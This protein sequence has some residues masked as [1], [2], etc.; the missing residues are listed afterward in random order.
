MW[1]RP[2]RYAGLGAALVLGAAACNPDD[3]TNQNVNPN[4]PLDA[5]PTA[6]FTSAARLAAARW[7]GTTYSLRQT[8]LTA[9]HLAEVQYPE[10]DQ[11][12][13][14]AAGFTTLTFNAAY[15]DELADLQG[16]VAS[17]VRAEEPGLYAPALALR[18]WVFGYL[19]DSWGDVPYSQAFRG[20]SSAAGLAPKCDA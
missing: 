19:T 3:L 1:H 16:V 13:R 12:Q 10:T 2:I 8:E 6:T 18:T 11:Y 5:P 7:H 9:Q 20:D 17:G 14:L 15:Y 4:A